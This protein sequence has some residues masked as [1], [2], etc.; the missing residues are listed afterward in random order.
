[1]RR[2]VES[3]GARLL[4]LP[5]Y[6][7]DFNPIEMAFSKIRSVLRATAA[8]DVDALFQAIRD[9]LPHIR[10]EDARGYIGHSGYKLG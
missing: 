3:T 6:S 8:R 1:M 7:P 5:P 10:T 4:L 9:A 2:G